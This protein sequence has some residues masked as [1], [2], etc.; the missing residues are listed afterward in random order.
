MRLRISGWGTVAF[1]SFL[2]STAGAGPEHF[3]S[4]KLEQPGT[5]NR[6]AASVQGGLQAQ[7]PSQ[8]VIVRLTAEAAAQ[9]GAVDVAARRAQLDTVEAE[10]GQFLARCLKLPGNIRVLGRVQTIMNAVF[11][12]VDSD[13]IPRLKEDPAVVRVAPVSNY[14]KDLS[15]TVPYIGA[16]AVQ[17]LGVTGAGIKVAVL[18]SGV[19]YFHAN[20]GGSGD[21]ADHVAN[22]ATVIEEGTFPTA[23]VVAGFDFV[24]D[25]WPNGD[26]APD[27]D[28]VDLDGHG[29]HVADIIGGTNGVAPDVDIYA[30]SV[31]SSVS[32]SCSGIALIQG[33][34]FSVDPN[35]DGDTSDRV[36]VINMSLGAGYG[37][38][39]DDDLSLAS[40]NA[41]A[42]GV[43]V[44]SSAGNGGDNPY[45][46]GT[47]SSAS[48]VLSVAQTHVPSASQDQMA[49]TG[50]ESSAGLFVA[51]RQPWTPPQTEAIAGS[52]QYADGAGGNLN[53]CAAF[54]A[55]SLDGLIVFV[56]R[57]GCFFSDKIRNIENAGGILGIIGLVAPGEPFPGGFGGGD[58][59]N[60]TGYMISQAAGDIL[61]A[62]NAAVSFDPAN[63][64]ALVGS[65]VSSSSRGPTPDNRL[66]PEIGAPGASVSAEAGTGTA[67]TPFGGTSGASP[68]VAG[69]AALLLEARGHELREAAD[70]E[71]IMVT[72]LL[73]AMIVNTGFAFVARDFTGSNAEISRIGGGE[74]RADRASS[75]P[76]VAWS[77]EDANPTISL[78]LRDITR[79]RTVFKRTI[80]VKNFSDKAVA[81][82]PVP[83]FLFQDDANSGAISV[84]AP[85]RV[86][87]PAYG[88]RKFT[89]RWVVHGEAL[90]GNTMSSGA[91]GANPGALTASEFDGYLALFGVSGTQT[92]HLPWH[93]VPRKA[94]RVRQSSEVV[95]PAYGTVVRLRNRGVGDAQTEAF[96]LAAVSPDIPEGPRGGQAPT[97]DLRAVGS[98]VDL[99][100]AGVCSEAD[101][102]VWSFAITTHERQAHLLHVQPTVDLD[103]DRDGVFEFSV[104]GF[105]NNAQVVSAVFN[106]ETGAGT[107]QFFA[108]H[109]MNSANT[110]LRVCAE[111]LGLTMDNLGKLTVDAQASV[112]DST[113]SGPGDATGTFVLAPG[114]E[115]F[116]LSLDN[117]AISYRKTARLQ[118]ADRG[119]ESAATEL[120]ALVVTNTDFGPGNRGAATKRTEALIV[121]YPGTDYGDDD[122]DDDD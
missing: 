89:V 103:L 23:K 68:M 80:K 67:E 93:I 20:L 85:E 110:V 52:V 88:S 117:N 57:G 46:S 56:D 53:G 38:P 59:I 121:S 78:G 17:K 48:T 28:P 91:E 18:D 7:A 45:V 60:I 1:A 101:S 64:V 73:K 33:M 102:F 10:Q 119:I 4:L 50:P 120:G 3:Q 16:S 44:V 21:P 29:T 25:V 97:P 122:D 61:R 47:P 94:A 90:G 113:F 31:C 112:A 42:L 26:L 98:R 83:V 12:E 74:V 87:V 118:I 35:G 49:V 30:V 69:T 99:V 100:P 76:A 105:N 81:Y 15:D 39:F 36:D 37:Q 24:G 114:G 54:E 75:T 116:G 32:S 34:D 58:P 109:G 92:I 43:L 9:L 41:S 55:G 2:T 77:V 96:T 65:M 95:Q 14:E 19:D 86:R 40:D 63:A 108:E 111:Q 72:R 22:D 79:R 107:F 13:L 6:P 51:V 11:L 70:D 66:K 84:S 5:L 104:V 71:P 62:G 115:R 82:N 106:N 27:P 8:R